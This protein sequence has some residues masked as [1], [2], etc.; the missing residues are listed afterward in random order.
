MYIMSKVIAS[1]R[2]NKFYSSSLITQLIYCFDFSVFL[3][4]SATA[5]LKFDE[6]W[7][8]LHSFLLNVIKQVLLK[9]HYAIQRN[10]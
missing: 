8:K 6:I 9:N 5:P 10:V 1:E 4:V 3:I 7:V 2:K